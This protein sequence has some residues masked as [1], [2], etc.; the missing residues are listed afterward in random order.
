[1]RTSADSP[2]SGQT[3]PRQHL[4]EIALMHADAIGDAEGGEIFAREAHMRRIE[5]DRVDAGALGAMSEPEGRVAERT[6][7][8]EHALGCNGGGDHAEDGAVLERIGAATVLG[9]VP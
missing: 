4:G 9:A 7:E 6:A 3:Q 8:F 5:F 2:A 1:S